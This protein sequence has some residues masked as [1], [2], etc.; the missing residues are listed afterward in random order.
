[1]RRLKAF[2][3]GSRYCRRWPAV[4]VLDSQALP[5]GSGDVGSNYVQKPHASE[6]RGPVVGEE[7]GVPQELVCRHENHPV[8]RGR[9]VSADLELKHFCGE[10]IAAERGETV[11]SKAGEAREGRLGAA[12]M[13]VV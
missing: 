10:C 11:V 7:R 12:V 5:H 3:S 6:V 1:V 4:A 9:R 2:V 13:S 8:L